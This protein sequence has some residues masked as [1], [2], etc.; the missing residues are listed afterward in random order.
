MVWVRPE[1]CNQIQDGRYTLPFGAVL[2]SSE[3]SRSRAMSTSIA[4]IVSESTEGGSDDSGDN[5][6]S[7]SSCDHMETNNETLSTGLAICKTSSRLPYYL[8]NSCVCDSDSFLSEFLVVSCDLHVISS[9]SL[10][11]LQYSHRR[12]WI[13][14][15][16]LDYFIVANPFLD[17]ILEDSLN[18]AQ[19]IG[20]VQAAYS[21]LAFRDIDFISRT[22]QL[23]DVYNRMEMCVHAY[24]DI[25]CSDTFDSKDLI[26]KFLESFEPSKVHIARE[27]LEFLPNIPLS[28]R[29]KLAEINDLVLLPHSWKLPSKEDIDVMVKTFID[30]ILQ[31]SL[32]KYAP[33]GISIARSTDDGYTPPE[34]SNYLQDSILSSISTTLL[35]LWFPDEAARDLKLDFHSLENTDDAF[36]Y[37]SQLFIP[38]G[39]KLF[40]DKAN[41]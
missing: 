2:A 37:C 31:C 25:L 19:L 40:M 8:D 7:S 14:D 22:P 23:S 18:R 33:L 4:S 26:N 39:L 9:N 21:N 11:N 41:K 10:H 5:E 15:I 17:G 28:D 3:E 32:G 38:K 36:D 16:C 29:V 35:P 13:L 20:A 24:K 30:S 1:S 6:S 12:P 34:I 27:L